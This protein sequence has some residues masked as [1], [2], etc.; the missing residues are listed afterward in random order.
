MTKTQEGNFQIGYSGAYSFVT[1]QL[2]LLT[3]TVRTGPK[4]TL[5]AKRSS[6]SYAVSQL[7][8]CVKTNVVLMHKREVTSKCATLHI[9]LICHRLK[10]DHIHVKHP[11]ILSCR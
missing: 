10:D 4:T 5:L 2:S 7:P 1:A 8:S 3:V 6:Y 11:K 9:C